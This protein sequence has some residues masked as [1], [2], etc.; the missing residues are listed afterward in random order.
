[1][2]SFANTVA[3][4]YKIFDDPQ[5]VTFT[6]VRESGS[7][8]YTV[9]HA[10]RADLTSNE[11]STGAGDYQMGDQKWTLGANQL[12]GVT[13]QRGDK[14]TTSDA[15]VREV[16]DATLDPLGIAWDVTTRK[17]R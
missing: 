7:T 8:N 16:L 17:D 2:G 1:V 15:I 13:P 10:T 5:T 3:N 4:D 14:L 12:V 11:V 9:T 6:A